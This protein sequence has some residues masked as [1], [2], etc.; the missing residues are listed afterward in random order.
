MVEG[1]PFELLDRE[2]HQCESSPRCQSSQQMENYYCAIMRKLTHQF[3]PA[4]SRENR[5]LSSSTVMGI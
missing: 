2:D 1:F 4:F 3:L 5:S